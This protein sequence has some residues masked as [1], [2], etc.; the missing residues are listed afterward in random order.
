MIL[1]LNHKRPCDF[2]LIFPRLPSLSPSPALSLCISVSL[3]LGWITCS[4]EASSHVRRTLK[5]PMKG[6]HG[7]EQRPL[8]NSPPGSW[9]LLPTKTWVSLEGDSTFLSSLKR[10]QPLLQV[11]RHPH[12]RPR[13]SHCSHQRVPVCQTSHHLSVLTLL[14]LLVMRQCR[15]NIWLCVHSQNGI[16]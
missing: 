1:R 15:I 4:G 2:L 6:P 16:S 13:A 5:Q 10:L 7:E 14:D 3:S 8:A 9:S 12:E 11:W